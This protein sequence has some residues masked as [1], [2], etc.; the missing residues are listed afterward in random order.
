MLTP[1]REC[2]NQVSDD[3]PICP[4]CGAPKPAKP[5]FDGFGFEW[6][7][8]T[9]ILGM[10]FIHVCFKYGRNRRP[11]PARGVIAIGQFAFGIVT[12]A[13]FGIGLVGIGQC[14]LAGLAVAQFTVAG[15]AIA[16]CGVVLLGGRGQLIFRLLGF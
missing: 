7:T 6:R 4:K 1:C 14:L 16:Q 11:K 10:P 15:S 8:E 9:E 2:K 5:V 12:I 3:A 13:Q